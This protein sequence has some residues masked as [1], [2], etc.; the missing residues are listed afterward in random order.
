M[1]SGKRAWRA[2]EAIARQLLEEL[3]Y[4]VLEVHKRIVVDGVEIGEV[5]AIAEKEGA[6]YAVEIKAG[7]LDVTGV[8]QAYTNALLLGYKPLVIARGMDEKAG[9]LADRLGV[10]TIILS[11]VIYTSVDE[12]RMI[13]QEAVYDAIDRILEA[14]TKCHEV[15]D[16]DLRVLEA[17][18]TTDTIREAAEAVDTSV[19][20]LARRIGTL[21]R[22]GLLP[23]GNYRLVRLMARLLLACKIAGKL[24]G[25]P[26]P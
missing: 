26:R 4:R 16:D 18:A 1:T 2:S 20:D 12:V 25:V 21:H 24:E 13:V 15:D 11:D 7:V 9:K 17:I 10:D 3:G 19:E 22:R 23:R 14:F 6:R 8:R 5:D